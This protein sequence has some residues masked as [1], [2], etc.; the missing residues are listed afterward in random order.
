MYNLYI[1]EKQKKLKEQK[2][3]IER[4]ENKL[5]ENRKSNSHLINIIDMLPNLVSRYQSRV[6]NFVLD[7]K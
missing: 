3:I 7:V 1:A 6:E 4:I 2:I 5:K